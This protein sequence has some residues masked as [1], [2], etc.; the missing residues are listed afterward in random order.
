M[1]IASIIISSLL[2]ALNLA[3]VGYYIFAF[4]KLKSLKQN[5]TVAYRDDHNKYIYLSVLGVCV[6]GYVAIMVLSILGILPSNYFILLTIVALLI[7]MFSI[8]YL[9]GTVGSFV[10]VY[11]EEI[12]VYSFLK[13]TIRLEY[14]KIGKTG[15]AQNYYVLADDLG[16]TLAYFPYTNINCDK[17]C[18]TLI[19]KNISVPKDLQKFLNIYDATKD[20]EAQAALFE[21]KSSERDGEDFS[22]ASEETRQEALKAQAQV[23]ENPEEND[24]Q[25]IKLEEIGRHFKE[26]YPSYRKNNIIAISI[27][28]AIV[29]GALVGLYFIMKS[30]FILI[31]ALIL[32]VLLYSKIKELSKAKRDVNNLSDYD[33]GATY[34]SYDKRIVGHAKN[35]IKLTRSTSIMLAVVLAVFSGFIGY[36]YFTTKAPDY[37]SLTTVTGTIKSY[38]YN[39]S[40]GATFVLNTVDGET[41]QNDSY[42]Y[43]L[44]KALESYIDAEKVNELV[45]YTSDD[46][47]GCKLTVMISTSSSSTKSYATYYVELYSQ[48]E[49]S[50]TVYMNE[51]MMDK[52]FDAYIQRYGVMFYVALGGVGLV[53]AYFLS[54]Y[55]YY[56]KGEK[57]ETIV[58]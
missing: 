39:T 23:V 32:P 13:K 4:K 48:D 37:S 42:S 56:K 21:P 3:F 34:Y 22:S 27:I 41:Y 16:N 6:L 33:L 55:L 31:F 9:G 12:V 53:G 54:M 58:L 36:S 35:K 47:T 44:P 5:E 43:I 24:A 20:L 30:Y 15:V 40:S 26:I 7:S 2:I 8:V 1:Q 57:D 52:Y 19:E 10:V 17:V 28:S 18:L 38:T 14:S 46:L 29:I 25:R 49:S 45:N 11:P 50:S 51:E